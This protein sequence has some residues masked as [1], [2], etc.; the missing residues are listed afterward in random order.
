MPIGTMKLDWLNKARPFE[1]SKGAFSPE[2]HRAGLLAKA[3]VLKRQTSGL[4]DVPADV[5]DELVKDAKTLA[6]VAQINAIIHSFLSRIDPTTME[7][8]S[9]DEMQKRLNIEDYKAFQKALQV[10]AGKAQ[11]GRPLEEP[12]ASKQRSSS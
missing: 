6:T 9:P 10:A 8:V 4:G 7:K 2:D 11:E 12:A 3:D 5:R 1:V